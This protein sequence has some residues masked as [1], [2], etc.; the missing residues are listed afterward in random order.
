MI[1]MDTSAIDE[2]WKVIQNEENVVSWIHGPWRCMQVDLSQGPR[3]AF[4]VHESSLKS[5]VIKWKASLSHSFICCGFMPFQAIATYIRTRTFEKFFWNACS[6]GYNNMRSNSFMIS[7]GWFCQ[8]LASDFQTC[9]HMTQ[10]SPNS[11][12]SFNDRKLAHQGKV[13]LCLPTSNQHS[14]GIQSY[15][16]EASVSSV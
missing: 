2:L 9:P 10:V 3:L 5:A 13:P 1:T 11:A 15:K 6:I 14:W 16:K 7:S 8:Q 4:T 12:S